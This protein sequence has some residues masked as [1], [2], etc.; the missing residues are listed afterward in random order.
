[1]S[2]AVDLE[3]SCFL[4][5]GVSSLAF[6]PFF[7]VKRAV[8]LPIFALGE[9]VLKCCAVMSSLAHSESA[10]YALGILA[11]EH[12][13]SAGTRATTG[14]NETVGGPSNFVII[15]DDVNALKNSNGSRHKRCVVPSINDVNVMAGLL[16]FKFGLVETCSLAKVLRISD[17]MLPSS[18]DSSSINLRR[19]RV[20][21]PLLPIKEYSF[22][23]PKTV[24]ATPACKQLDAIFGDRSSRNKRKR[25]LCIKPVDKYGSLSFKSI[26]LH[27][28]THLSDA[29]RGR[30]EK[31]A[32]IFSEKDIFEMLS[33]TLASS[34]EIKTFCG[35]AFAS[36]HLTS[37]VAI[38]DVVCI[39]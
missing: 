33:S 4:V 25:V 15:T 2:L 30:S 9:S 1:M 37:D 36:L 35:G 23:S 6:F 13:S 18:V 38:I 20:T 26:C 7:D 17:S 22:G 5:L 21:T 24:S 12:P 16:S 32:G 28:S 19:I 27:S 3:I 11:S 34:L 14:S 31:Y 10:L 8:R 29:S 39:H